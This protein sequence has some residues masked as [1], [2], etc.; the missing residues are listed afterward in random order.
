MNLQSITGNAVAVVNPWVIASI[1]FSLGYSIQD[2]GK[3]T[4]NY[5]LPRDIKTQLQSLTSGDVKQLDGLNIQGERRALYLTGDLD[6]ISRPD[7]SG[8]DL[9][10]L[11]DGTIWL[12]VYILENWVL[13]GGWVKAA[14][15]RQNNK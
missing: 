11:P 6:G 15:V 1:Q 8:G 10:T 13:T 12:T 2:G 4:P 14:V 9:V 5:S 7:I 3:R